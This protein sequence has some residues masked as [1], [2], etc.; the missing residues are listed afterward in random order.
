M[1]IEEKIHKKL[2]S[3]RSKNYRRP[4]YLYLGHEDYRDLVAA[5]E[6]YR[7]YTGHVEQD[8]FVFNGLEVF[9]VEKKNHLNFGFKD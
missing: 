8:G 1:T 6:F 4:D 7:Q 2:C 9:V 3:F 5:T